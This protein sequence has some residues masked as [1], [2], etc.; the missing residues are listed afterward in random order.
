M[1]GMQIV[2]LGGS[3]ITVKHSETK[4]FKPEVMARLAREIR[5]SGRDVCLVHG[6]GCYGH[7][8]ADHYDLKLGRKGKGPLQQMFEVQTDVLELN[9]LVLE[10]LL[11]ADISA[12]MIPTHATTYF[13]GGAAAYFQSRIYS[14]LLKMSYIPVSYG[15]VVMDTELGFTICSGDDI[16]VELARELK[17]DM[18][19]FV[20]NVD[21]IY[22]DFDKPDTRIKQMTADLGEELLDELSEETSSEDTSGEKAS[23][24][25]VTGGIKKKLRAM[26]DMARLGVPSKLFNGNTPDNLAKAL[27]GED[28]TCTHMEAD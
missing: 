7:K 20:T 28:I 24:T 5:V 15:D 13:K 9:G 18:G 27:R 10:R 17:P 21:G 6:A 8:K 1:Q 23:S 22:R 2:K 25:D 12:V 4:E 3:V 14:E 19:H 16:M 26:I 11:A